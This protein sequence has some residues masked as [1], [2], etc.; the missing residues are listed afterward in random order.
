MDNT[1]ERLANDVIAR[2]VEDGGCTFEAR[3][4]L[5]FTPSVGY[6]VGIG[7]AKLPSMHVGPEL[8][9]WL[10]KAVASEYETVYAGTWLDNG[11]VY[12]DAVKY[13]G[14]GEDVRAIACAR[15]YGQ[16]AL[17]DFAAGESIIIDEVPA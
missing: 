12:I 8:L 7:G 13:F 9:T 10:A 4:L 15:F 11:I 14:A 2:T 1:Q 5:P 3:T 6:A 16:A 17:Y